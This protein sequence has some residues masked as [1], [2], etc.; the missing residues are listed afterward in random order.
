[1]NIPSLPRRCRGVTLVE[2]CVVIGIVSTLLGVALSALDRFRNEQ[3][4]RARAQ[5]LA[6]DVRLAR[7]EAARLGSPVFLRVSG[8]GSNACYLL[9]TGAPSACDCAGGQAACKAAGARVIRAEWFASTQ[10]VRI[11]SNAESM[12]FQHG[13]GLVTQTGTIELSLK[14]GSAIRHI[15]AITGRVRSCSIGATLRGMSR[16]A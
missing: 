2:L 14:P 15:V 7:S 8:K 13:Q 10:P 11:S 6:D 5:A 1:M 9:H 12:E 3:G 16:C 4:L